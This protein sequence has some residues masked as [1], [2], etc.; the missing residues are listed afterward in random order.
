MF[1]N[2]LVFTQFTSCSLQGCNSTQQIN[3]NLRN[4]SFRATLTPPC[5]KAWILI[6]F[7]S[8]RLLIQ[9][10]I[11]FG[12]WFI[13]LYLNFFKLSATNTA[14]H[15]TLHGI[16]KPSTQTRLVCTHTHGIWLPYVPLPAVYLTTSSQVDCSTELLKG[17]DQWNGKKCWKKR[18]LNNLRYYPRICSGD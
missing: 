10:A 7:F 9:E 12:L 1:I 16:P 2:N 18:A 14:I 6:F 4:K 13:C 11:W 5:S 15:I 8:M 3:C 17:N